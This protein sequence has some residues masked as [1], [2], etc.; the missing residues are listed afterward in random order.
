MIPPMKVV[1]LPDDKKEILRR[2]GEAMDRGFLAQGK[3]VEEFEQ[4]FASMV[5]VKHAIATSNGGAALQL[6]VANLLS[7]SEGKSVLV[8]TNTFAATAM[9][10]VHA[11]GVPVFVDMNPDTLSPSVSD[12]EHGL[13]DDTAGV[14]IVHIGGIISPEIEEIRKWCDDKGLWLVEDCAHAHGSKLEGKGAGTFG[15][16]GCYS[17]F[18]TKVMTSGEGG[19]VVTDD[20]DLA[21]AV[22]TGRDYGKTEPWVSFHSEMGGNFRM[23]ELEAAVGVVQFQ[24]LAD[25]IRHRSRVAEVYDVF[26]TGKAPLA[27]GQKFDSALKVI[28]PQG[29]SSWYKYVVVL[30]EEVDRD[31]LKKEMADRGVKLAGGVFETPLHRQPVFYEEASLPN[32]EAF[33]DRHICLP[34]YYRMTSGDVKT[35]IQALFESLPVAEKES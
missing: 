26:L 14:V 5:G 35:V 23:N 16:A 3:N 19:M 28:R 33:A 13:T 21:A 18:A 34:I 7:K 22:R 15:Q 1:F 12:L 9:S 29:Q 25:M 32:A 20:D 31:R 2:I 17:F 27:D 24:R 11:G 6:A 30:P 8:P 4:R 10:V